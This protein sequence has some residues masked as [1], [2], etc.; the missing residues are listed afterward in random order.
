VLVACSVL[1]Q[2]S[3]FSQTAPTVKVLSSDEAK[4]HL[5]VRYPPVYPAEAKDSH[6]EGAVVL[7]TFVAT[8]G[9]VRSVRAISGPPKLVQAAEDAVKQWKYDPYLVNGKPVPVSTQVTVDFKLDDRPPAPEK[10]K[11]T[12]L[13]C[14]LPAAPT[15]ETPFQKLVMH[16]NGVSERRD[17]I[18]QGGLFQKPLTFI[19]RSDDP[20]W[21]HNDVEYFVTNIGANVDI[22]SL[23]TTIPPLVSGQAASW[24]DNTKF[25]H[26]SVAIS[27]TSMAVTQNVQGN[28]QEDA[29][30]G[31]VALVSGTVERT[32]QCQIYAPAF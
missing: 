11:A 21:Q 32:G 13:E 22:V 25:Y 17:D 8:N 7:R 4:E 27:R 26:V 23:T 3:A 20:Q 24:P 15:S 9:S 14:N 29:G 2:L 18:W 19:F 10:P 30:N 1:Y 5:K 6:I 12:V 28:A 16:R 31:E